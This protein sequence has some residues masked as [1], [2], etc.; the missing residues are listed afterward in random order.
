VTG[1]AVPY[2]LGG[3]LRL[4]LGAAGAE[5]HWNG[6]WDRKVRC[7]AAAAAAAGGSSRLREG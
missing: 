4:D 1:A 7:I 6:R 5:Q 3:A 2:L